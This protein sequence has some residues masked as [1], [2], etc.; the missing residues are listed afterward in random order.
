[1]LH[2]EVRYDHVRRRLPCLRQTLFDGDG[3]LH[4]ISILLEEHLLPLQEIRVV[5]DDE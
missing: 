1:M 3:S 2:H 5:V 4:R